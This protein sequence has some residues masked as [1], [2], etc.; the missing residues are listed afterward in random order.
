MKSRIYFFTALF[1][2][3]FIA[4]SCKNNGEIL[5]KNITGS[6]YELLV[7]ISDDS[8][9]GEPGKVIKESLGQYQAGLPQDEPIF[10][11]VNVPPIGF[12]S[13]F[14]STRNIL[15]TTI[16]TTVTKP[17]VVF[18]DDIWAYPQATV[19]IKA[20]NANDWAKIYKEN[21]NKIMSYFRAAE[22]E[23]LTTSYNRT[24]ELAVYNVLS[25][26]FGVTMKVP[27]G[28]AIA[29]QKKDFIWY[30]Y[31]TP[32]IS[33][34]IL[35]Y[36]IPYHS[37]STFTVN[38]LVHVT[39]SVLKANVP[40]PTEGSYPT[41]EKRIHQGFNVFKHNGN[42]ASEMR[43]LWSTVNDFMGGPYVLLAELD[44]ANQRVIIAY[45]YVYAPSK[46]KRNF[47]NQVEAMI[48]SLK[49]NN[50]EDN[51]KLNSQTNL[52]IDVEG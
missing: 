4:H 33:Q 11:L 3:M 26:D 29:S 25:E 32:D 43:G 27:P 50:Q 48:Y 15:M 22:M 19:E 52:E 46:N 8:W 18:K 17:Q 13:I 34:G 51:D 20:K 40:G 10:N 37:D 1:V 39:D 24:F 42:Y 12:K 49:L 14:K 21:E 16:S 6:A 31:E 2:Y 35:L 47:I 36:P 9:N 30:R 23:R 41:I 45:G 38:Y 44:L 5:H 28:F 7:V